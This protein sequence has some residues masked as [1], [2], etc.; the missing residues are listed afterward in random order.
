LNDLA[1]KY[2]INL[3]YHF[4]P[5]FIIVIFVLQQYTKANNFRSDFKALSGIRLK[6]LRKTT[7]NSVRIA[8]LQAEI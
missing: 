3:L 5:Y 2:N 7:K 6:R 8:G 1:L 4:L